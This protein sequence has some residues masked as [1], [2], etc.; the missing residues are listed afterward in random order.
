MSMSRHIRL[1]AF[2]ALFVF[3]VATFGCSSWKPMPTT[4]PASDEW[5]QLIGKKVRLHEDDGVISL[6]VKRVE[7]PYIYGPETLNGPRRWQELR[8]DLRRVH[9]MEVKEFSIT[10]TFIWVV[11]PVALLAIALA[12]SDDL[13][14]LERSKTRS[15]QPR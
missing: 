4:D 9:Q 14:T 15:V 8:Y 10:K 7:Y 1:P 12:T 13:V 5:A 11:L 6:W 2:V 3:A